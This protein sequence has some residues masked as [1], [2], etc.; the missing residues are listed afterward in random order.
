[1][2]YLFGAYVLDTEKREL[3]RSNEPIPAE[4]QVFDLLEFL[5][6]NR[7][8]VVTKDD[9]VK[10]VWIGRIVSES[11]LTSRIA[12]VRR[13]VGDT[14]DHQQII[15]TIARKGLRF[16]AE[17]RE[18]SLQKETVLVGD[19]LTRQIAK[20][21][22]N[23]STRKSEGE[24]RPIQ[25]L[26]LP[27]KP[28]IVV[29]PFANLSGDP[30]QEYF[31]DGMVDDITI[32][33]GRLPWLFVIGSGSAFTYKNIAVDLK[34]VGAELGV[35]YILRG[36]VRKDG[37]RVRIT[38][39]LA[40]ASHGG[41]IWADR[42]DEE[43]DD[44]FSLQD[45]VADHVSTTIAP[46]LRSA[47][48]DRSERKPTDNL[49]AYDLF[50]R[51]SRH[52]RDDFDQNRKSLELLSRAVEL[53][54]FYGGA[55]GLAA[56]CIFWQKV[57]GWIPPS[58]PSIVDGVRL[59]RLA[60]EYGSND[61]EALWMAA[62]ASLMLA[63]D[64]DQAMD[65][66]DRSTTLN[67]NSSGAWWVSCMIHAFLTQF[68]MALEHASRAQRL[69]PLDP[70]KSTHSTV[71][72]LVHFFAGRYEEAA[73]AASQVLR[74]EESFPPALRAMAAACGHLGRLEEGRAYVARLCT[75]SPIA[76]VAAVRDYYSLPMRKNLPGLESLL[77]GLRLVGL[78]E[79]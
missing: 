53:D 33:L 1:V 57:F 11:T 55:Y 40:D 4:P 21:E 71:V 54:P 66:I 7:D 38:A 58:S 67:P 9:L 43:L 46:A 45:R 52:H 35:R 14:G 26:A 60:V 30:N 3:H 13:A 20:M 24:E 78:S 76:S 29:L 15:R 34:R 16:V 56:F 32:S 5:I 77:E 37:N 75:V 69:N 28:S 41:H 63:G 8:H 2:I 27:D 73:R 18:Q 23:A 25:A 12:E 48:I 49:S 65:L 61:S 42:F 31:V 6:R 47:E 19:D 62:Q 72:A 64:L 50:L 70:L 74:K 79:A 10:S 59:A 68:D 22:S 44:I 39:Q 51:A 36:S 17:V